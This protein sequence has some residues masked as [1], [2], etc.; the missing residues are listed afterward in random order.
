M[1]LAAQGGQPLH[2][3]VLDPDNPVHGA[4]APAG[5]YETGAADEPGAQLL[6]RGTY[7]YHGQ[8]S[9]RELHGRARRLRDAGRIEQGDLR[10][11]NVQ[12]PKKSGEGRLFCRH[13]SSAEGALGGVGRR[14]CRRRPPD[15]EHT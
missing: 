8:G 4:A 2:Q 9:Q 14:A 6:R 7:R 5:Q 13:G 12:D 11:E 1:A 10:G 15:V 3:P